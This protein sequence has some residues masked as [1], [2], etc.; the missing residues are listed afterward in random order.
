MRLFPRYLALAVTCALLASCARVHAP[1]IAPA[2]ASAVAAAR[3]AM[4]IAAQTNDLDAF[5]SHVEPGARLIVGRD[6]FDL[7][8]KAAAVYRLLP[9][10]SAT[11][12]WAVGSRLRPC[13]R[14]VY[15]T[16][17]EAGYTAGP[18]GGPQT[19]VRYLYSIAWASDDAG[20]AV[21]HT[22]AVVNRDFAPPSIE[23]CWPTPKELFD[24][25]RFGVAV[26]PGVGAAVSGAPLGV[27]SAMRDR[28]M[29]PRAGGGVPGFTR[30]LPLTLPAI[31]TAWWHLSRRLTL[32]AV[33]TLAT[34]SFVT[35]GLDT[36][37]ALATGM[38]LDQRWIAFIASV[39][40][41][42][43]E[44]GVGPAF[45]REAWQVSVER[46]IV[47]STYTIGTHLTDAGNTLNRVGFLAQA[48][49][50]APL[51]R[52]LFVEVRGHLLLLPSSST[53]SA[54]GMPSIGVNTSSLGL[55]V[56]VGV[57]L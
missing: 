55:G 7:R 36:A 35:S 20:N 5:L 16:G 41:R 51:S 24:A 34:T 11:R 4:V 57:G 10:D 44:L 15:E 39:R 33:A 31:G 45:V 25:R 26:L 52:W 21:V 13:N 54:Y 6:T 19:R 1:R 49:I 50:T 3:S 29:L 32:E 38:R 42:D 30:R 43:V 40:M 9:P 14:W 56:L 53:P 48:R 8:E 47:D 28:G 37:A 23:G 27:E 17:G 18:P 2:T 46:L 12:S 22:L